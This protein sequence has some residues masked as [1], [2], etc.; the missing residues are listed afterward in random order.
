MPSLFEGLGLALLEGMSGHLPVIA[1]NG[2]AMLP[3]VQGAGG[4]S[5]DPGN[6]EQL[7]AALDTYL[8]LSDEELRAKGE[9]VFR[10][11]EE[12]HTLDEF[13]HKYL[14]LIETGLREVGKA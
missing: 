12:N 13:R 9:Q 6:V 7:A 8:A 4:L 3:L 11:L 2:P 5:H 1:S 14:N 10:Y